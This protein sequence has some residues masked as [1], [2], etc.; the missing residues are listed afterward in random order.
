MPQVGTSQPLTA[1]LTIWAD[2]PACAQPGLQDVCPDGMM[3]VQYST[4]GNNNCAC[5]PSGQNPV[6]L[7]LANAVADGTTSGAS[8]GVVANG[9]GTDSGTGLGASTGDVATKASTGP[10]FSEVCASAWMYTDRCTQGTVLHDN[11]LL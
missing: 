11:C 6:C 7:Q 10:D 1:P 3:C 2:F 5:D 9:A 4:T 8:T